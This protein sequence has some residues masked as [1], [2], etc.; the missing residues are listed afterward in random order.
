MNFLII[1]VISIFG[2][3]LGK[4]LF[5]KW[6]NHLTIYCVIWGGLVYLYELKL[7]PYVNL[8]PLAWFY[9]ISA[10]ISF[11]L[12]IITIVTIKSLF[13]QDSVSA[14]KS[15]SVFNIFVDDG[16][17]LKYTVFLFS[18]LCIVVAI[19]NWLVLIKIFGSITSVFINSNILYRLNH[20]GGIDSGVPYVSILGLGYIAVFFSGIYT[21]YK[22]KFTL[23]TFYPFLGIIIQELANAGRV[24]ILF[25]SMEFVFSFFLFRN[26]LK[27][28]SPKKLMFSKGNAIFASILLIFFLISAVSFIR[29]TRGAFENYVGASRELTKNKNNFILSPS[30]Y[31]YLSSDIGV[32]SQYLKAGGENTKF[33]QNSFLIFYDL[34]AKL[35]AVERPRDFQKGYYIPMWT[36]TGTYIR[37]LHADFGIP[38]VFLGPYLIG[39]LATWFWYK[40]YEEKNLLAFTLL[41]Y[42]Y[43]IVGFSFLVMISRLPFFF[44]SLFIIV[45]WIRII[46]K[47]AELI[48]KKSL[49]KLESKF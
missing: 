5:R 45:I 29:I 16:K 38:G 1:V 48:H 25:A 27:E 21:A 36:N 39:L 8:I 40:F 31:L 33:G 22:G 14:K 32:L 4:L 12:G 30:V 44:I 37:E 43:L 15:Y 11:L 41:I 24:G 7:L 6:I 9:I 13:P 3:I 42:L 49:L 46:E 34:L 18:T 28:T 17:A 47:M 26:L 19:L 35:G 10:F 20:R 2:I 23:L